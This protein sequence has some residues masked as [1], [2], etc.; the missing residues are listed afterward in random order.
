[1]NRSSDEELH[2]SIAILIAGLYQEAEVEVPGLR[3]RITPLGDLVG[4]LNLASKELP[5]LSQQGAMRYLIQQGVLLENPEAAG[6]DELAGFLYANTS[7]GCIFLEA[8]DHL[9]RRRFSVAHELGHYLLHFRPLLKIAEGDQEYFELTE[10]LYLGRNDD[11][12]E[13]VSGRVELI[14][15]RL[16]KAHLPPEARMEYEANQFATE[17]LMPEAVVRGLFARVMLRFGDDDLVSY[18]AT[19]MLVSQEAMR[20]R[21]RNFHLLPLPAR[22]FERGKE[23]E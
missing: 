12:Q 11:P 6:Q 22:K 23:A 9:T 17:L 3:R 4:S 18:L 14:D 21:L 10:A 20:W 5:G 19:E 2:S 8:N 7:Y 13:T 1:M 15:Q 16:L